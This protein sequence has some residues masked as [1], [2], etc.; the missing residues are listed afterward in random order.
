M[1]AESIWWAVGEY[2]NAANSAQL[3]LGLSELGNNRGNMRVL[4]VAL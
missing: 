4:F 2:E 3:D 1:V